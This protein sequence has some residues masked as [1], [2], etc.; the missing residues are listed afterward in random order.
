MQW[1][2]LLTIPIVF[3]IQT[4]DFS[5]PGVL[6]LFRGTFFLTQVRAE[7]SRVARRRSLSVER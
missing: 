7:A 3:Y 4:F 2:S 6:W 1:R 5:N